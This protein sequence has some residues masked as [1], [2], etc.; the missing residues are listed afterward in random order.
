M[1]IFTGLSRSVAPRAYGRSQERRSRVLAEQIGPPAVDPQHVNMS[2]ERCRVVST[3]FR[4]GL[5]ALTVL[6]TAGCRPR[7][8][9]R[10]LGVSMGLTLAPTDTYTSSNR[11]GGI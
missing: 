9:D 3:I 1:P 11:P 4:I 7:R 5:F 10:P 2:T 6:V 8:G